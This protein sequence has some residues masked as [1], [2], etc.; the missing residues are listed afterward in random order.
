MENVFLTYS[1]LAT[2]D[3]WVCDPFA[4]KRLGPL[5]LNPPLSSAGRRVLERCPQK[6]APVST[7]PFQVG[8][9]PEPRDFHPCFFNSSYCFFVF[10]LR[11]HTEIRERIV[12]SFCQAS[13]IVLCIY[14][15]LISCGTRSLLPVSHQQL[16]PSCLK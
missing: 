6:R 4:L 10:T 13:L 14:F 7:W 3:I 16:L 8:G 2:S 9:C 5:W 15:V 1:S 11:V 12:P